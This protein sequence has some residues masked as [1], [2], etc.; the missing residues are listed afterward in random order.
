MK[1][2]LML[3]EVVNCRQKEGV[4]GTVE[5]SQ[6]GGHLDTKNIYIFKIL[7]FFSF[8]ISKIFKINYLEKE[9]ALWGGMHSEDFLRPTALDAVQTLHKFGV[10]VVG[11]SFCGVAPVPPGVVKCP[12]EQLRHSVSNIG[13]VCQV[14]TAGK[15]ILK[16]LSNYFVSKNTKM[17]KSRLDQIHQSILDLK[18]LIFFQK[19]IIYTEFNKKNQ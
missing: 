12:P 7:T 19:I 18:I 6:A 11:E 15:K 10:G 14:K 2:S 1:W 8:K 13:F 17:F 9:G 16:F 4:L 3:C 5:F